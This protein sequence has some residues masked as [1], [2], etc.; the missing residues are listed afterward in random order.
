MTANQMVPLDVRCAPGANPTGSAALARSRTGL[1]ASLE[2]AQVGARGVRPNAPDLV[3]SGAFA[4][5]RHCGCVA[6][7][8]LG[9]LHPSGDLSEILRRSSWRVRAAAYNEAFFETDGPGSVLI[10]VK[11]QGTRENRDG[12]ATVNG[13]KL[14]SHWSRRDRKAG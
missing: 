2:D 3:R 1:H 6:V 10:T 7:I 12:C 13:H 5:T 14:H 9:R 4:I 11:R 8:V